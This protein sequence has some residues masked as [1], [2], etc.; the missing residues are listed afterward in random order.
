MIK[1]NV[2][3]TSANVGPGFDSLGLA[4]G[5]YNHVHIEE[6]DGISISSADGVRI[7]TDESNLVYKTAKYL[8][9]V[10]GRPFRGLRIV[11]ENNIPMTRGLGSSSACIIAG[12]AGANVLLGCP[13]TTGELVNIAAQTEGHPDNVAP[14]LLG[15]LVTA[16]LE[17]RRVYYVKQDVRG[18]IKF[19]AFIP[20]FELPT[21]VARGVLPDQVPHRDGV[22]NLSRAALMSVSLY[23]GAF[24]NLR[25]AAQDRLH[26]PYRLQMIKGAED[27][28]ELCY[29]LG[30]YACYISGAGPTLIAMIPPENLQFAET[31]EKALV[32]RGFPNWRLQMLEIDNEGTTIQFE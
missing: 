28:F 12:L 14:A 30:A 29:H 17:N 16:V 13:M 31:A 22:Y 9:D 8:Y 24:H 11:Q 5:L 6:Y 4:L 25:I 27:I 1:I 23:S 15:G 26:Q 10:C 7:P 21:S 2:P 3:A 32:D 18:K 19:A 20:D